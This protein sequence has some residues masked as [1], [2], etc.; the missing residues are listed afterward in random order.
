MV[1]QFDV[2]ICQRS[3]IIDLSVTKWFS[4]KA[5]FGIQVLSESL[6]F[7]PNP[8]SV[9]PKLS[10]QALFVVSVWTCQCQCWLR[11]KLLI[12]YSEAQVS[13]VAYGLSNLHPS[14]FWGLLFLW[15]QQNEWPKF[16]SLWLCG[17]WLVQHW[18]FPLLTRDSTESCKQP[19]NTL[20]FPAVD[21]CHVFIQLQKQKSRD[22]VHFLGKAKC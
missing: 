20:H 12:A 22:I 14:L 1:S 21:C 3:G 6:V 17:W 2:F 16:V 7:F 15:V 9:V 13:W 4:D 11:W 8:V 18:Q 10:P 5:S 19:L